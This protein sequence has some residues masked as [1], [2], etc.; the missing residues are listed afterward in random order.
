MK[1]KYRMV[2]ERVFLEKK[3]G[4]GAEVSVSQARGGGNLLAPSCVGGVI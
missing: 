2:K 1:K 3:K 4:G